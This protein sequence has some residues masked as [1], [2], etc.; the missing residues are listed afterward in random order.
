MFHQRFGVFILQL[1]NM[2]SY[3]PMQNQQLK[4][5]ARISKP[6]PPC[7]EEICFNLNSKKFS[8]EEFR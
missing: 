1:S 5:E 3:S 7:V 6:R 8:V 2:L 4:S